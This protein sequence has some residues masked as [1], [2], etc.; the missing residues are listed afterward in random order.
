LADGSFDRARFAGRLA[1]RRLG[2]AL[3]VRE[4]TGSTNDDAFEA[5]GAGQPDGVAVVALAQERG[6]GRDGRGWAQVPGRGLAMSF[7]L[8]PGCGPERAGLVPLAAGLAVARAA[9][10]LGAR[11]TIKWPNDVLVGGRK[12]AGVLCEMRRAPSGED[13][14]VV[15]TGVNVAH[16]MDDFPPELRET[17]T[18]LALSGAPATLEDAAAAVLN[19]FEPL[20]TELQEGDPGAVLRA[21]SERA[22]FWGEPVSV[23]TPS[24]TVS[25]VAQ[26]LDGNGGL[27]LR[28]ESGAETTVLAGDVEPGAAVGRKP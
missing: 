20:W 4:R 10:G 21:W 13:I 16:E 17:A 7:A 14:V 26:R 15:G 18:S 28:L 5:I 24:G 8:H 27:V 22:A 3:I 2:R 9:S 25:G 11:A 19:A 23:R 1:T 6:R 12:L